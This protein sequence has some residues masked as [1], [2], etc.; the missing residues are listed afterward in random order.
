[1][2]PASPL[3]LPLQWSL[4]AYDLSGTPIA[5]IDQY[6]DRPPL[7]TGS[8]DAIAPYLPGIAAVPTSLLARSAAGAARQAYESFAESDPRPQPPWYDLDPRTIHRWLG[9]AAAAR[10]PDPSA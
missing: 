8:I 6:Q 1:M 2:T 9:I 10:R 4:T 3:P 7:L 5:T